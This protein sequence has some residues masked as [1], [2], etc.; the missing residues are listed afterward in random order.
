MPPKKKA[1]TAKTNN[2]NKKKS[3]ESALAKVIANRYSASNE[4]IVETIESATF[5][6]LR[7]CFPL[8]FDGK[9]TSSNNKEWLKAVFKKEMSPPKRKAK[10]R[11]RAYLAE[12]KELKRTE[13]KYVIGNKET[14]EFKLYVNRKGEEVDER[15][16]LGHTYWLV[17]LISSY[18]INADMY[19]FEEEEEYWNDIPKV[20]QELKDHPDNYNTDIVWEG[21]IMEDKGKMDELI[22]QMK[23]MNERLG[24]MDERIEETTKLL[25]QS[26]YHQQRT[27]FT[28]EYVARQQGYTGFINED[29]AVAP[30]PPSRLF[31]NH[32]IKITDTRL[33][34][35]CVLKQ[36]GGMME[37]DMLPGNSVGKRWGIIDTGVDDIHGYEVSGRTNQLGQI[38]EARK[39]H[40]L[41]SLTGDDTD[42]EDFVWLN[43]DIK[44]GEEIERRPFKQ[45]EAKTIL[46]SNGTPPTHTICDPSRHDKAQLERKGWKLIDESSLTEVEITHRI[47]ILT[48]ANDLGGEMRRAKAAAEEKK[49]Q[50]RLKREEKEKQECLVRD[51]LEKKRK[52][53][54]G[55]RNRTERGEKFEFTPEQL[56]EIV[57]NTPE[58]Q[59]LLQEKKQRLEEEAVGV[60][61]EDSRVASLAEKVEEDLVVVE[62]SSVGGEEST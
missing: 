10:K 50:E 58:G 28:S 30:K 11:S 59:R 26:M 14:A 43:G 33:G 24:K 31:G 44:L 16:S 20:K 56:H 46:S 5:G 55:L 57:N 40:Y 36:N 29:I 61:R 6:E 32:F 12:L 62:A 3:N 25:G 53:E 22:E 41:Q 39:A 1:K 2:T 15:R 18:E 27:D 51:E 42:K 23:L 17:K 38:I 13:R 19:V 49:K 52:Y 37:G 48:E 45:G 7:M 35:E 47:P 34:E 4:V 60:P 8:V 21:K 9:L 54:E